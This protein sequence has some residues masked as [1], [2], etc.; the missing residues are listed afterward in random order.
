[1][2]PDSGS[3]TDGVYHNSSFAFSYKLPFSWVDR[4]AVMQDNTEPGKS[5]VLLAAFER[6]PE[7]QAA[8]GINSA[9]VIAAEAASSYPALKSAADYFA[10]LTGP[11]TA[12]GFKVADQPYQ[13]S[14][15][16]KP[17]VRAD[18]SKG[19]TKENGA[20]TMYQS[21]LVLL[22]RGYFVS[23]TFIGSSED[24]VEELIEKLTFGSGKK[25]A[26]ARN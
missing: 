14:I 16:A 10:P 8:A 18:F 7:A 25:P 9:V 13:F 3:I 22:E 15:G 24:E 23:F 2:A 17:L 20:F 6:P 26:G 1:M 12:Q 4:T 11:I 5:M 19:G 21:S